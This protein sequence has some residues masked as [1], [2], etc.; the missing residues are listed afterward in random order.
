MVIFIP[1]G[2]E[3]DKTRVP[4][5]YDQTFEFLGECGVSELNAAASARP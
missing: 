3:I 2:S 4:E 1:N 5:F